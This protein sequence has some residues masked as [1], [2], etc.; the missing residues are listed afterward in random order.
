MRILLDE[1]LPA[2]LRRDLPGHDVQTVPRAGWAGVKNGKLLSLI[3]DAAAF[4]L[5][6]T[7]DKNLS[8]EYK[9]TGLPFAIVIHVRCT[10][11]PPHP[12]KMRR[13]QKG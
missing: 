4:D 5:F 7:I 8:H 12:V 9:T 13:Q 2:R 1:C 10:N 11:K 3:A 6:V